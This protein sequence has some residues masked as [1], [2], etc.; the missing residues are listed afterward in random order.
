MAFTDFALAEFI[1]TNFW[2]IP[3]LP[4][5]AFLVNGLILRP[6]WNRAAGVFGTLCVFLAMVFAYL[7]A[8]GYF[9]GALASTSPLTTGT[10]LQIPLSL[11]WLDLVDGLH[12]RMGFIVDPISAMML[13]VVTTIS[14]LVHLYSLEYM[15]GEDGFGRYFTYLSL[16][17]F[18]MLGLVIAPNLIQIYVFWELVGASSFLLIGYYYDRPAAVSASK[19]AF[20]VTRFADLGFL[21]GILLLGYQS[22]Q[23]YQ[24]LNPGQ[25]DFLSQGLT[26]PIQAVDFAFLTYPQVIQSLQSTGLLSLALILIYMGAAGKSAM[27]PLHIW[28]PDAMEGP[29]PVSALIHAATMVVAGVYLVA[30]LFLL[31]EAAP[32]ALEV[33]AVVGLVTSA[34]AAIIACTQDDIK[35]VLAFSTL[36]QLG[37]MM[38]ALGIASRNEALGFSASMFHLYTH[39]FFKALLFLGAGSIIH[40]VHTNDIWKMGGLRKHLP[41]THL[42]F[43]IAVLAISGI[44]PFAG[45]FSKDEILT[46]ALDGEHYFHFIGGLIVAGLTAFYMARIYFLAFHGHSRSHAPTAATGM[47]SNHAA[48]PVPHESGILMLIP[49]VVLAIFSIFAGFIPF[50]EF[51]HAPTTVPEAHH[52]LNWS[53]AI[54]GTAVALVGL[55]LSY[56]VYGR[57]DPVA[58]AKRISHP[59]GRLYG[60]VKNKFYFDELYLFITHKLIFAWIAAPIAWFDRHIVDGAVNLT[61]DATRA[62][63]KRLTLWQ[64]GQLQTYALWLISGSTLIGLLYFQFHRM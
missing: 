9:T 13:T 46:A 58:M 6:F 61:G 45:F 37:Y 40:A 17:T 24:T 19:K 38:F 2:L 16:F 1:K 34:L 64:T 55:V 63:G 30:R 15:K 53:V 26:T 62:S 36:S 12:V 5:L 10:G 22:L 33:V 29:T 21:I 44:W 41:V 27:F 49:L 56:L 59:W 7:F 4:L 31:F 43:L 51:V 35:R 23:I 60:F 39:A 47:S 28:L 18:S 48:A 42:T 20:I 54:P 50:A 32:A 14:F 8:W 3:L 57:K 52:G 11:P 25:I